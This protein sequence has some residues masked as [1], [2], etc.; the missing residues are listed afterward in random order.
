MA[1]L[2]FAD[3]LISALPAVSHRWLS[4]TLQ[5][6]EKVVRD[7]TKLLGSFDGNRFRVIK[8]LR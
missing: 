5:D 2:R 1:D 8:K 6:I 3:R 4:V 7:D